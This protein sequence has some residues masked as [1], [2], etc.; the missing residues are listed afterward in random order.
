MEKLKEAG[1]YGGALVQVSGSIVA[2]Y[3]DCLAMLGL[4]P[5]TLDRFTVDGMGWSPEIALEQDNNFYLNIGEA[6]PNAIIISPEQEGKPVHMPFH[7]FDRDIMTAIFAAYPLQIR[8]I[9][10]DLSLIHI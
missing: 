10:K 2:R 3:N 4:P 6:N 8:D 1:L 9:T 5:T 7:S